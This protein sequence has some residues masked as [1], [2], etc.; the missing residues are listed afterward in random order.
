MAARQQQQ[1]T[2]LGTVISEQQIVPQWMREL[3]LRFGDQCQVDVIRA[4][5]PWG[6]FVLQITP[7]ETG[8]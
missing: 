2:T 6:S 4:I 1:T 5:T 3:Q 8:S 7:C